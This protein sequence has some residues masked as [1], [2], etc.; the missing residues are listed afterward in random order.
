[1]IRAQVKNGSNISKLRTKANKF[2]S[3]FLKICEYVFS[4]PTYNA[5]VE[6]VFS[7]MSTQWTDERN[8]LSVETVQNI[9]YWFDNI[10]LRKLVSSFTTTF[11]ANQIFS[12]L[13]DPPRNMNGTN[14][15]SYFQFLDLLNNYFG[16][17]FLCSIDCR[18]LY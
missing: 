5:N 18:H 6:R 11:K 14:R 10:I 16:Y 3:H 17:V 12:K 8:R 2:Y 1:M 4:I 13:P 7:L 9:S 15:L